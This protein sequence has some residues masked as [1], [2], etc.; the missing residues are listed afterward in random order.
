[1]EHIRESDWKLLR[2]LQPVA[3][4]RF[5]QRLLSDVQSTC[6]DTAVSAHER[7][8]QVFRL[9]QDQDRRMAEIFDDV[10]RSNAV[11]RVALMRSSGLISDDEFAKFSEELRD[12][13]QRSQ[14]I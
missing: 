5:C 14:S 6:S 13:V 12:V 7:Y 2:Q 4:D 9:V 8:L 1:M 10:R 3:I 11:R